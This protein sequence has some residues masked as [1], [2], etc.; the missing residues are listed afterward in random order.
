MNVHGTTMTA[1]ERK[2][3]GLNFTH[4]WWDKATQRYLRSAN[5]LSDAQWDEI[6]EKS[7]AMGSRRSMS[8]LSEPGDDSESEDP[9]ANLI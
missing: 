6:I 8:W 4:G 7:V 1:D 5:K 9:R 3:A 2:A